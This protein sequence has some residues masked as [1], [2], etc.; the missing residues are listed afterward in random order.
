MSVGINSC[1]RIV[2]IDGRT[3]M[4]YIWLVPFIDIALQLSIVEQIVHTHTADNHT[5]SFH[6]C[7][8]D[9]ST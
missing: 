5:V 6:C 9:Y 8:F 4:I 3:V 2:Q 7:L 1:T